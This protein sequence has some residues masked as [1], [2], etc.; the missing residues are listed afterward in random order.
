MHCRS[1]RASRM[2]RIASGTERIAT[3]AVAA[4]TTTSDTHSFHRRR[5]C[6]AGWAYSSCAAAACVIG[7]PSRHGVGGGF[8]ARLEHDG[9]VVPQPPVDRA[10]AVT[11]LVLASEGGIC[12]RCDL[13]GGAARIH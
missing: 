2:R 12:R 11:V 4:R 9:G 10:D 8:V 5:F 7:S 13:Y 6:R 1:Y 3:N